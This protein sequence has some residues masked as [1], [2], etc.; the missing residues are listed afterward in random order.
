VIALD[1]QNISFARYILTNSYYSH[2]AIL[3]AYGLNAFVS[4][5]GVDAERFQRLPLPK[6]GYVLSVGACHHGKGFEFILK[7]LSLIRA[8][9]RPKF[10]IVSNVVDPDWRTYLMETARDLEVQLEIKHLVSD[11]ELVGLYNR[12]KLFVYGSY[13][14]PFGLAPLEAMACGT[15]VVAVKE[16]GV[17]ESVLHKETGLL[18]ERDE[19]TFAEA[20]TE[21]LEDDERRERMGRRAV[22]VVRSFWTLRHAGERLEAHLRQAIAR[23]QEEHSTRSTGFEG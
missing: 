17:R 3:R 9:Q 1:N 21:L 16:G 18:T 4:Y 19:S 22:E 10:V 12:A 14:E 5:L 11:S 13:L 2:E 15:P 6:E 8:P 7:S 20:T 23:G